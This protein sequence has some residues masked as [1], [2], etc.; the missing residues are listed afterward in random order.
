MCIAKSTIVA[1]YVKRF[2]HG[3]RSFLGPGSE[4][5]G[6]EHRR[7]NRMENGIVSLRT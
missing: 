4:K 7:T 3:H 6:T 1:D 5:S 2:A